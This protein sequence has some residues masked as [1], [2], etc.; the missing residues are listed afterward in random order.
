MSF[1]RRL[2]GT[3]AQVRSTYVRIW[4]TYWGWAPSLLV[5][6]AVV[7]LPLGLLDA[8]SL[9]VDVDSL[10]ITSGIKVAALVLAVGAVTMTGLLGEIFFSGAIAISLTHPHG[11]RPPRLHEIASR[12]KYGRLIAVDIAFVAIVALGLILGVVPGL[13]AFIFLGLAGPVVEIEER[14]AREA[15]R[16]SFQLVR[17]SFWLVFWVLVPIELL[18]DA[19]GG[20]LAG[21][22]HHELGD[23]FVAS[24]LAE[25]LANAVLSPIF[26]VAA[27]LLTV[28]LIAKKEGG[29]PP[30]H[31]APVAA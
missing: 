16:R 1:R 7:F 18:G 21:W 19:I 3:Y 8:L 13:L 5:L 14:S 20:G 15:L 22:I 10:D 4:R 6:A 2:A 31:S 25:A 30:L 26:A 27:V 9:Q 24:W 12:I 29:A 17:G 23:T 11:E 28:D